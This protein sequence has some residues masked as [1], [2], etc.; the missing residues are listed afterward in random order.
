LTDYG[1]LYK[2]YGYE[3]N[4]MEI[5]AYAAE[6]IWNRKILNYIRKNFPFY[7]L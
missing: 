1:R 7:P 3:K 2:K 6:N 4:P 5:E